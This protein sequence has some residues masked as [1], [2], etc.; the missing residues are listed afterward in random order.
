MSSDKYTLRD[1]QFPDEARKVRRARSQ[2]IEHGFADLR[3]LATMMGLAPDYL[4]ERAKDEQWDELRYTY[5]RTQA[6]E[7][8]DKLRKALNKA[9]LDSRKRHETLGN[10]LIEWLEQLT[11]AGMNAQEPADMRLLGVK[12]EMVRQLSESYQRVVVPLREVLGLQEGQPSV[13]S[14]EDGR[15]VDYKTT[16]KPTPNA[17][18]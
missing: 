3:N 6:S 7:A 1:A 17:V 4:L 11:L 12:V 8:T 9:G 18:S 10:A 2:Y 14:S 5:L 16:F 15:E 13:D